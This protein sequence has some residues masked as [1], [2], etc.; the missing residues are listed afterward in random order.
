HQ[1]GPAGVERAAEALDVVETLGMAVPGER[2]ERL[3]VDPAQGDL[4]KGNAT[5]DQPAGQQATLAELVAAVGV[6]EGSR[7]L[8]EI[9]GLDGLRAHQPHGPRIGRLVARGGYAGMASSE[10]ALH[11]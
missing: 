7:L 11:A 6:T 2:D 5:L 10:L 3:A 9:K 8:V 4:D 1:S